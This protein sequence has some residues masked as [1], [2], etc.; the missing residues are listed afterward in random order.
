MRL[1]TG[2]WAHPDVADYLKKKS[3][4]TENHTAPIARNPAK[5]LSDNKISKKRR[6]TSL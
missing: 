6:P 2:E 3:D 4:K 5:S 1:K